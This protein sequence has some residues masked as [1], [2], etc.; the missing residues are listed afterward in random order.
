MCACVSAWACVRVCVSVSVYP[1]PQDG[2]ILD[3]LVLWKR[4]LDK[5][6][7]GVEPCPI[8]YSVIHMTH[9]SLPRLVCGTCKN[10]YHSQCLQKWF[11]TA[12]KNNCPMCQQP[13]SL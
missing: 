1:L 7:D 2:T 4:S 6:F 11:Q 3:A 13:I 9:H 12:N 5:E 10:K 8:C